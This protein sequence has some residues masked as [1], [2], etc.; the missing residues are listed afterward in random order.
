MS[1]PGSAG[2]PR[3][4]KE[5]GERRVFLPEF[6]HFLTEL[7]C[8]VFMEEG[9]WS[10]GELALEDFS[11]RCPQVRRCSRGEAFTKD[12]VIVL[13]APERHEFD[14]L[15]RESCLISMLHYNTRP[16][17]VQRLQELGIRAVSLDSITD[18]NNLRLVEN[19]RAVAWNGIDA[20]FT[21]L[22]H[23]HPGLFKRQEGTLQV[24]VLG[25]G[26]VG[27][28]AMEA[29]TKMG[30][31]DRYE[32][33][34]REGTTCAL[35]LCAG[36]AV[37]ARRELMKSL[38][39]RADILVD[40]TRRRTPSVPL[41]PN[42]WIAWLPSHSIIADLAVDPYLLSD[43]P[44]VV[45]GIE[46]IPQGNLDR[47]IFLPEDPE[48]DQLI[49]GNIPKT[50][51]RTVVSCYSWPGIHPGACMEHYGRQ[52]RPF[53]ELLVKKGY[54][55]LSPDGGYFERALSRGTLRA[56]ISR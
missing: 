17:R 50:H 16:W 19:M 52:L 34:L 11:R 14:L 55:A 37:T 45:R 36:R 53:M 49:P 39:R 35:A 29:A 5:K 21:E 51:R 8:E 20:A 38:L 6:L 32:Q 28:H 33:V 25:T 23:A 27:K 44:P 9:Y 7:G 13:R 1:T 31:S 43:T 42:D 3:M 12:L 4:N 54:D 10:D 30:S 41:V 47:Y 22:K 18:D 56:W 48:W 46:G 2:F 24:L 40:A 15:G 26:T